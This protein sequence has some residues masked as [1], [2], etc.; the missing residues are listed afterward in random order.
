MNGV[1]NSFSK[2][3][4]GNRVGDGAATFVDGPIRH[5]PSESGSL[6]SKESKSKTKLKSK[7]NA[8]ADSKMRKKVMH[9]F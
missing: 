7:A 3:T 6:H 4:D 2:S 1:L 5:H 9:H 8:L